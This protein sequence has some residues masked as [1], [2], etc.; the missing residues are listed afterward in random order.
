MRATGTKKRRRRKGDEGKGSKKRRGETSPQE[1]SD[2]LFN[3]FTDSDSDNSSNTPSEV[4]VELQPSPPKPRPL[5]KHRRV[6]PNSE[7]IS[8]QSSPQ[9]KPGEV[10]SRRRT[11]PLLLSEDEDE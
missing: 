6:P 7:A 10:V 4:E 8:V 2:L 3:H 5:A 11:K 9:S 1:G